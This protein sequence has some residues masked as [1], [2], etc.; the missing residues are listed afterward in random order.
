MG[1]RAAGEAMEHGPVAFV[2]PAFRTQHLTARASTQVLV[3]DHSGG[4]DVR[5]AMRQQPTHKVVF[6]LTAVEPTTNRRSVH[7]TVGTDLGRW[8]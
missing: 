2:L 4:C 1:V 5:N 6:L 7:V 8:Q 3:A